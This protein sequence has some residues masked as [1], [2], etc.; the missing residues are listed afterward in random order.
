M[1]KT[2]RS[3]SFCDA[4]NFQV[5]ESWV[6]NDLCPAGVQLKPACRCVFHLQV[7]PPEVPP[8]L[9]PYFLAVVTTVQF[10]HEVG[11]N[12][13]LWSLPPAEFG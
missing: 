6:P 13:S 9:C 1:L 2:G 11:M 10:W 7:R 3:L 12:I 8:G 4:K 5:T